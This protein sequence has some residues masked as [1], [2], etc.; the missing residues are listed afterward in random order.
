MGFFVSDIGNSKTTNV[1]S[2]RIVLSPKKVKKQ[3]NDNSPT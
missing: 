2:N 3:A 1:A